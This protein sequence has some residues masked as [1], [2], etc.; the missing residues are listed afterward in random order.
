MNHFSWGAF[1]ILNLEDGCSYEHNGGAWKI[2]FGKN[3]SFSYKNWHG[4]TKDYE[5]RPINI[6]YGSTEFHK[7]EQLFLKAM[8]VTRNVER[9]FAINDILEVYPQIEKGKLQ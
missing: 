9:D 2:T 6:W 4:E 1:V 3:V 5:V 8:D 7:E